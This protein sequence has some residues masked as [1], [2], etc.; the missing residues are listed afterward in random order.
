MWNLRIIITKWKSPI[1]LMIDHSS[2]VKM[3]TNK[4]DKSYIIC[5]LTSMSIHSYYLS[6]F[7]LLFIR[8]VYS[9][10]FFFHQGHLFCLGLL[11]A[12]HWLIGWGKIFQAVVWWWKVSC[13]HTKELFFTYVNR[14]VILRFEKWEQQPIEP[15]IL[16]FCQ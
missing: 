11:L 13:Q 7:I 2:T 4:T 16:L 15:F 9:L 1:Q 8:F 12:F 14:I 5:T 3:A 10:F 6:N